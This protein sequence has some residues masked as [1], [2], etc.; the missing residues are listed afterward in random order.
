MH[1]LTTLIQNNTRTFS[2]CN[3]KGTKMHIN[4]KV[5]YK[6]FPFVDDM[7]FSTE[8]FQGIYKNIPET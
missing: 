3:K 6:T 8:K 5:R 7:I 2:P 4:L 1:A